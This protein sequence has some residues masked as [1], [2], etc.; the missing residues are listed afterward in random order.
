MSYYP[1][2]FHP[3]HSLA[4]TKSV[5]RH[6]VS[7][8]HVQE[9]QEPFYGLYCLLLASGFLPISITCVVKKPAHLLYVFKYT[10]IFCVLFPGSQEIALGDPDYDVERQFVHFHLQEELVA[11]SRYILTL[12]YEGKLDNDLA[13]LYYSSYDST[14]PTTGEQVKT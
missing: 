9:D 5:S 14:N 10:T 2:T 4:F 12:G 1:P 8:W 6:F 11:G 3:S 7:V 13:G